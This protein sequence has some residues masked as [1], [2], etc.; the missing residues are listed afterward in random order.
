MY[1]TGVG[2]VMLHA[3]ETWAM[4]VA[5]LSS[6]RRYD[7]SVLSWQRMNL[8]QT[9]FLKARHPGLGS[10]FTVVL[11]TNRMRWFGHV[12]H[13]TSWI[14]EVRKTFCSCTEETLHI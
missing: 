10:P 11:R 5:M 1:S 2:S 14:A 9:T 6:L 13:N 7:G 12:E 3:A 4:T 8:A